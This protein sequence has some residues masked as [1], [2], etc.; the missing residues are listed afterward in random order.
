MII[1]RNLSKKYNDVLILD[2]YSIMYQNKGLFLLEGRNG[3]G[4][5]TLFNIISGFD[6]DYEGIIL[7]NDIEISHSKRR[8]LVHYLYQD[9]VLF[10]KLTG[11]EHIKLFFNIE[12]L[13]IDT[14]LINTLAHDFDLQDILNNKIHTYSV[15]QKRKLQFIHAIITKKKIILLD[16]PFSQIDTKS[17]QVMMA[18][19]EELSKTKLVI[20][21]QHEDFLLNTKTTIQEDILYGLKP[22]RYQLGFGYNLFKKNLI[23]LLSIFIMMILG[24]TIIL[25]LSSLR[26]YDKNHI[27]KSF[28]DNLNYAVLNSSESES[29]A[30]LYNQIMFEMTLLGIDTYNLNVLSSNNLNTLELE[31]GR[32]PTNSEEVLIS[33]AFMELIINDTDIE[34]AN[35]LLE[36]AIELDSNEMLIVGVVKD[37]FKS[38]IFKDDN[39]KRVY[40]DSNP[41]IF[42]ENNDFNGIYYAPVNLLS[43]TTLKQID[44]ANLVKKGNL[45]NIFSSELSMNNQISENVITIVLVMVI[46]VAVIS[47]QLYFRNNIYF[48]QKY[49]MFGISVLKAIT[50]AALYFIFVYMCS[51]VVSY[52]I[53]NVIIKLEN[54]QIMDLFLLHIDPFQMKTLSLYMIFLPII[55]ALAT[56]I[57][58]M[59]NYFKVNK[60]LKV[61]I[62]D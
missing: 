18:Y 48:L 22:Q 59:T 62:N 21:T 25:S 13:N 61:N 43:N 42:V 19:M 29:N 41:S 35:E 37:I 47:A 28:Y 11:Y 60:L 50:Y 33:F 45:F 38:P 52:M 56:F 57:L 14:E 6:K 53:S 54:L 36:M 40:T 10:E 7:I 51:F 39:L 31:V 4:K 24:F 15:G 5:T 12:K 55:L 30:K 17:I 44:A 16:E 9:F 2:N 58:K 26:A 49:M 1:I 27:A 23:I 46:I 8:K 34:N 3:S 20:Y 32:Y